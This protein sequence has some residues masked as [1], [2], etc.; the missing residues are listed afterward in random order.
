MSDLDVDG[1]EPPDGVVEV[2]PDIASPLAEVRWAIADALA[3]CPW[4]VHANVVDAVAGPCL[5]ILSGSREPLAMSCT[6]TTRPVILLVAGRVDAAPAVD[7]LDAQECWTLAHLPDN[8]LHDRTDDETEQPIGGVSYLT[9][10]IVLRATVT[11]ERG[12]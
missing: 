10:R 4:P 5:I 6:Y 9:R 1:E 3:E 12:M 8:M 11:V 7:T 2:E